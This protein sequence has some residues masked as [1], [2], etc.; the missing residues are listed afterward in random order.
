MDRINGKSIILKI[1]TKFYAGMTEIGYDSSAKIEKSLI[2]EDN[3]V[4]VSEIIGF[5]EKFSISGIIGVNA[6]GDATTHT[7]WSGIRA[8]YK[9]K[10]PVAFVY[11]LGVTAKPEITGNLLILSYSEK[12]ASTGKATYTVTA[13]I[14]QDSSLHEGV[15]V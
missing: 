12:S 7:D 1:G 9:A 2:K 11:G 3:G 13:E 8:A 14:V 5:D 15:S 6:T 10:A 4:E